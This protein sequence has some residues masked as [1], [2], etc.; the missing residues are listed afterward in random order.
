LPRPAAQPATTRPND[1]GDGEAEDDDDA[2]AVPGFGSPASIADTGGGGARWNSADTAGG[3]HGRVGPS[4][5]D[6][7][8][9]GLGNVGCWFG[10]GRGL[11]ANARGRRNRCRLPLR[12]M[13]KGRVASSKLMIGPISGVVATAGAVEAPAVGVACSGMA[14]V[15]AAGANITNSRSALALASTRPFSFFPRP[16]LFRKGESLSQF[17]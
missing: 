12:W 3:A 9:P 14:E 2:L 7:D 15:G 13:A 5:D 6:D 17:L 1:G 11:M 4:T 8:M 10:G 16:M